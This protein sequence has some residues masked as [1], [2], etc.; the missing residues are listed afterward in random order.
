MQQ[1]WSGL[2]YRIMVGRLGTRLR[3]GDT[4]QSFHLMLWPAVKRETLLFFMVTVYGVISR[5]ALPWMSRPATA[6]I[7]AGPSLG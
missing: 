2:A 6:L 3:R 4:P 7:F 5:D 1:S